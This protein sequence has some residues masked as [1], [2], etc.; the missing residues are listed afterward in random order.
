[1]R[2]PLSAAGAGDARE[3]RAVLLGEPRV[4]QALEGTLR[5]WARA[6]ARGR[7]R[8][9][10]EGR[11]LFEKHSPLA[12]RARARHALRRWL[13]G[14]PAPRLCEFE[15]LV[16]LRAHGFAA[17]R[18]VLAGALVRRGAARF[19]FLVTEEVPRARTL[20]EACL[21]RDDAGRE[22]LARA[23]G[24]EVGRLHAA[25]FVHRD[26]FPRNVLVV[27]GD[28]RP[29]FVDAW[30]G[31]ARR[32]LRG[33]AYDLGALALYALVLFGPRA[34]RALFAAY[35][36]TLDRPPGRAGARAR[37]AEAH[38]L[39]RRAARARRGLLARLRGRP[40]PEAP[41]V[42]PASWTPPWP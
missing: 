16:W 13:L 8:L 10:L 26:L 41:L 17:P 19:Q 22:T 28:E 1:M 24:A 42:A 6:G 39:L 25:G 32:G 33:P 31:G 37:S 15:N 36:E 9:A 11:A 18:P 2:A 27:P 20:R 21:E 29:L 30:R 4:W 14:R 5:G 23:L 7:G 38:A 12:G 40:S 34:E 3:G 35:F